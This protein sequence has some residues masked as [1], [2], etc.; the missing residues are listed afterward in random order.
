[1]LVTAET[2]PGKHQNSKRTMLFHGVI[3]NERVFLVDKS[4]VRSLLKLRKDFTKALCPNY[5]DALYI[6]NEKLF[7]WS[8][9]FKI[10]HFTA[11]ADSFHYLRP[12]LFCRCLTCVHDLRLIFKTQTKAKL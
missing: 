4:G 3:R 9:V 12:V 5:F 6:L 8:P 10:Y 11:T 1:M 7:A 2:S